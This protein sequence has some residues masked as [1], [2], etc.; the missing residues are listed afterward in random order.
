METLEVGACRLTPRAVTRKWCQ[1]H[2]TRR[3]LLRRARAVNGSYGVEIAVLLQL[4]RGMKLPASWDGRTFILPGSRCWM[5]A[6][7]RPRRFVAA[8]VQVGGEWKLLYRTILGGFGP[9]DYF[10][11]SV[12]RPI[13]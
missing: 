5:W 1:W 11:E 13:R 7:W 6:G 12:P 3:E 4:L 8:L 2:L 10:L 9:Q